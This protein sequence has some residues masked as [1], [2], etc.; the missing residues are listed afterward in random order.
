VLH[1]SFPASIGCLADDA[2]EG[3]PGIETVPVAITWIPFPRANEFA[4]AGN[5]GV[6]KMSAALRWR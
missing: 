6:G 4:L 3:N 5:D 2:R 1:L